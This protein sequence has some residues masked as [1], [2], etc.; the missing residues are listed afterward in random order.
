M[1]KID[2][3]YK[4]PRR[5]FFSSKKLYDKLKDDPNINLKMIQDYLD[6]STTAQLHTR[7]KKPPM[8]AKIYGAE[9]QYQIDLT[10]LKQYKRQNSNYEM[11]MVAV[12]INGRYAYTIPLKNKYAKSI[13]DAFKELI[14]RMIKD[15]RTPTIFQ[16]DNGSEFKNNQIQKL[17]EEHN[18]KQIFC[19]KDDKKCLSIAERFNRTI[20]NLINKYMTEYNTARWVD[21]LDDLTYNYN[22]TIHSAMNATPASIDRRQQGLKE[23][24]AMIHN[25]NL[26]K[27]NTIKVGDM[28]RLPLSKS[29]FEKEGKNFSNEIFRVSEVLLTNLRVHGRQK[30]YR[31]SEVL[32]VPLESIEGKTDNIEEAKK[33]EKVHRIVEQKEGIEVNKEPRRYS[34]RTAKHKAYERL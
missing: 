16:T 31:I 6:K 8:E 26:R 9:G 15:G 20:K 30:K 10:F 24:N 33:D 27:Q 4:D 34:M 25:H 12:Q 28:V 21:V 1:N 5:G 2:E 22:H 14:H 13:Y 17:C 3:L 29:K 19:Q 18:I 32:K 23:S 7:K 11:I